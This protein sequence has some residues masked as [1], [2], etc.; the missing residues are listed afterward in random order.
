[1]SQSKINKLRFST[2]RQVIDAVPP[3]KTEF[4]GEALDLDPVAFVQSLVQGGKT[5]K[6]LNFC[7]QLLSRHDATSWACWALRSL[8]VTW[9]AADQT[10]LSAAESWAV[11]PSEKGRLAAF[12]AARASSFRTAPAWAAAAAGF[13]GG[14]MAETEDRKVQA[15]PYLTGQAVKTCFDLMG[16]L[17]APEKRAMFQIYAVAGALNLLEA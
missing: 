15:P 5:V 6:A 17:V 14:N 11:A 7:S 2:A 3:L 4:E 1:M 12:K 9:D 16:L 13:A 10:L 8:P